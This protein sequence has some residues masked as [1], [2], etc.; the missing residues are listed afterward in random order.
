M[1]CHEQATARRMFSRWEVGK[2]V[3]LVHSTRFFRS[4]NQTHS[5][6]FLART[7]RFRSVSVGWP[8]MSKRQRV[9]CSRVGSWERSSR[10]FIRRASLDHSTRPIRRA[11]SLLRAFDALSCAH[12]TFSQR[13]RRMACHEQATARRMFSRWELGKIISLVHSTRFFRSFNQTHSTRFKLA[14][15]IRRAFLRAPYVFAAFPSDG[16]P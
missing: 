9:E 16:L 13:F 4:F 8:A 11:L 2:I 14:Q 10:W 1:A 6:R 7:L 5:T 12:L 3:S 15:G